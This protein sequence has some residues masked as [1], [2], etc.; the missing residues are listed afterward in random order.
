MGV[1]KT[2]NI[3]L[4]VLSNKNE[5]NNTWKIVKIVKNIKKKI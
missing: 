3:Q 5:L 4:Y 2:P 1:S